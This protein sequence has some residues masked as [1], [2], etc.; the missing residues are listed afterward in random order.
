[1]VGAAAAMF[2]RDQHAH[3]AELAELGQ[4]LLREA[5]LAIPLG[6][7]RGQLVLREGAG[8]S[9]SKRCSSVSL[10]ERPSSTTVGCE[11]EIRFAASAADQQLIHAKVAAGGQLR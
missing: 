2:R 8:G 3:E 11:R 7:V 6:G 1:M 10:I 9:R 4:R 5:R